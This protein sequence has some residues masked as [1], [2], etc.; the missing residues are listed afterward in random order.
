MCY[1]R[2]DQFCPCGRLTVILCNI[3]NSQLGIVSFKSCTYIS[4]LIS[5]SLFITLPNFKKHHGA[6]DFDLD[7]ASHF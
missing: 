4:F 5:L 7:I 6:Y 2:K 1:L 3:I